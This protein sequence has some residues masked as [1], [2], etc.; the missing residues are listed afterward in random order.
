MNGE[1]NELSPMHAQPTALR[2]FPDGDMERWN[3]GRAWQIP[4]V[5]KL[6]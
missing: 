2:D 1:K 5:E 6:S 3:L 4:W